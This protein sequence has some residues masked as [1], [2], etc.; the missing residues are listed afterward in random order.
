MLLHVIVSLHSVT[1]DN[2]RGKALE[3][4]VLAL[5]KRVRH[6]AVHPS[7]AVNR[8]LGGESL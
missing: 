7:S 5:G 4:L 6:L 2:R 1:Q 3:H 8:K